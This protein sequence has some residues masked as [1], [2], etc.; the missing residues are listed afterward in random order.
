MMILDCIVIPIINCS[1]I[2]MLIVESIF[3]SLSRSGFKRTLKCQKSWNFLKFIFKIPNWPLDHDEKRSGV[4]M[5]F[6]SHLGTNI[7]LFVFLN[8]RIKF[9]VD[10]IHTSTL[11]LMSL[12][13]WQVNLHSRYATCMFR[14]STSRIFTTEASPEKQTPVGSVIFFNGSWVC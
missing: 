14:N 6:S 5:G 3:V 12:F 10:I 9:F 7:L 13:S 2:Y 8:K 1:L 4:F 11:V